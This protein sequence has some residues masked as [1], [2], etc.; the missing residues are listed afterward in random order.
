[1]LSAVGAFEV[2]V[3]APLGL[4]VAKGADK[5]RKDDLDDI[6]FGIPLEEGVAAG[7]V[8]GIRLVGVDE[9][10]LLP[11]V[12]EGNEVSHGDFKDGP[13]LEEGASAELVEV[14]WPVK[15]DE[16]TPLTA[17]D[18]GEGPGTLNQRGRSNNSPPR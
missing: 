2:T 11:G 7:L 17:A 3:G 9:G 14:D 13:S 8:E 15:A 10:M 18:A 12:E 5:V 1:M 6:E 4:A 16:G